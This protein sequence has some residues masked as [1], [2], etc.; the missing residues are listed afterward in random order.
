MRIETALLRDSVRGVLLRAAP[1]ADERDADLAARWLVQAELLRLPEFGVRMLARDLELR[2]VPAAAVPVAPE[3]PVGSLDASGVPGPLALAIAVN[4]ARELL[5]THGLAIIGV[6]RVGALGV[7]G[8][9]ARTIAEAGGVAFLAAQ[10][11]PIVAPWGATRPAVGTNP[12]AVAL[13]RADAPPLTLDYATAPLTL[14]GV[15]QATERGELLAPGLAA[16]ANGEPTL[17]PAEVTAL[18]P[19][20]LLGS[21]TGLLVEALAGVATGGRDGRAGDGSRGAIV[22][23]F[24]P[25]RTGSGDAGA[26]ASALARDWSAAGGHVPARFDALPRA[27]EVFPATIDVGEGELSWLRAREEGARP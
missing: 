13:P 26:A 20:S 10:S 4:A 25:A 16:D 8:T 11:R 3:G 23:A 27:G 5:R 14:A 9:A 6:R 17:L 18:L 15:R 22:I 7:L 21:L 24:D 1:A 2:S 19:Q 12:I